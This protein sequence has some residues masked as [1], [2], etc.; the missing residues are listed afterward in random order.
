MSFLSSP[1][2]ITARLFSMA[3][4][5]NPQADN[6]Y[7]V[8]GAVRDELLGRAVIE[9]DWVVIGALPE[10]LQKQ[11]YRQVGKDFP[12]FISPQTGEEYALARTERKKGAGHTGFVCDFSADIK[13]EEDLKRRD[14]TVNAIAKSQKGELIDPFDG[15]TDLKARRLR[16]VSDSFTEDPLRVLRVARFV[17]Q[18]AEWNFQVAEETAI[19]LTTMARSGELDDLTAERKWHETERALQSGRASLYFASLSG[20]GALHSLWPQSSRDWAGSWAADALAIWEQG[21]VKAAQAAYALACIGLLS[22]EVDEIRILDHLKASK[23]YLKVP[24]FYHRF[25]CRVAAGASLNEQADAQELALRLGRMDAYRSPDELPLVLACI[26]CLMQAADKNWWRADVIQQAALAAGRVSVDE[27]AA[28][29]EG[30][31]LGR[32]LAAKRKRAIESV[33]KSAA[34]NHSNP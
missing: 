11:G 29:L 8:G 34:T 33:L 20:W 2:Q 17:A 3:K 21:E 7:L 24:N 12:V 6:V 1:A 22:P 28:E 14:L 31:A 23:T 27:K 25:A 19:L 4:P 30:V 15:Q 13:L 5:F 10:D 9:K 32:Y 18:L 26:S 16:H